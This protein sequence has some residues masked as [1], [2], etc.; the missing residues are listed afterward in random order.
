MVHSHTDIA[1]IGGGPQALTLVTHLLQK[2]K[3]MRD[4]LMR[5]VFDGA[6]GGTASR[7]S[8]AE[9]V[10]WK[11]SER[12]HCPCSDKTTTQLDAAGTN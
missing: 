12:S 11:A 6:L 7:A 1:V 2:N 5:A 10:W 4:R 8:G 3:Q 9:L